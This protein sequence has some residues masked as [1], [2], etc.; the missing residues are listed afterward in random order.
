[1]MKKADKK[2]ND[3]IDCLH[4]YYIPTKKKY[5]RRMMMFESREIALELLLCIASEP[6]SNEYKNHLVS[7]A[8]KLAQIAKPV[9]LSYGRYSKLQASEYER[10]LFEGPCE[11]VDEVLYHLKLITDTPTPEK[12]AYCHKVL[13]KISEVVCPMV[14]CVPERAFPSEYAKVIDYIIK[15][16]GDLPNVVMDT[17]FPRNWPGYRNN[18]RAVELESCFKKYGFM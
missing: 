4:P 1:M 17:I 18:D 12:A 15:Q 14:A 10:E 5:I 11:T 3:S 13:W 8:I 2:T 7:A 16:G 6:D 9:Y